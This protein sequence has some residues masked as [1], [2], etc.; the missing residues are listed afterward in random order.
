MIASIRA[1]IKTIIQQEAAS[2]SQ[3]N[4]PIGDDNLAISEV[5]NGFKVIFG[6]TITEFR[7]SSYRDEVPV[8]VEIYK[9]SGMG[10]KLLTDYDAVYTDAINIRDRIMNPKAYQSELCFNFIQASS[11]SVESLNTNDKVFKASILFNVVRDY[12]FKE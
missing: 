5:Q 2:Y 1:Y 10:S 7:P 8:T 4:D 12:E 6:Q 9:K 11:I 3:L